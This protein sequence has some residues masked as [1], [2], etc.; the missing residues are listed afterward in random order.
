MWAVIDTMRIVGVAL[1]WLII[2]KDVVGIIR[3]R[4]D[5][6]HADVMRID[7]ASVTGLSELQIQVALDAAMAT[8]SQRV[9]EMQEHRRRMQDHNEG[10]QA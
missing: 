6:A 8:F 4:R 5:V 3:R 9:E 1:I 7:M 10:D 2:V